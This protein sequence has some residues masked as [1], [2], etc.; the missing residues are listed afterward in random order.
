MYPYIL[1]LYGFQDHMQ[2][3]R[4]QSRNDR[5]LVFHPMTNRLVGGD[6]EFQKEILEKYDIKS[7]ISWGLCLAIAKEN[8]DAFERHLQYKQSRPLGIILAG[9][10]SSGKRSQVPMVDEKYK[11]VHVNTGELIL[12]A[13]NERSSHGMYNIACIYNIFPSL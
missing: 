11:L 3:C 9:A 8:K 10:P 6:P 2:K 13:A 1:Q 5:V 7:D 4:E 12:R